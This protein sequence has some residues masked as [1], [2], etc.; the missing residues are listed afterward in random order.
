[1]LQRGSGREHP[2]IASDNIYVPPLQKKKEK[3]LQTTDA[4][5]LPKWRQTLGTI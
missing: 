1:M 4:W 5:I 2:A 3:K